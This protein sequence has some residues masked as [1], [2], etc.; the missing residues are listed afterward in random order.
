MEQGK[1]KTKLKKTRAGIEKEY[2]REAAEGDESEDGE[3][4]E[5]PEAEDDTDMQSEVTGWS[6]QTF[7][8]AHDCIA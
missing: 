1:G 8:S 5:E 7:Y 6:H 2:E 4:K 3:V